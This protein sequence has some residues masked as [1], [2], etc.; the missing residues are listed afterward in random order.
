MEI[1]K[2]FAGLLQLVWS[3]AGV[4]QDFAGFCREFCRTLRL[5][6]SLAGTLVTC[7][8]FGGSFAGLYDLSEYCRGFAGVLQGV[9][10]DFYDV[11]EFCGGVLRDLLCRSFFPSPQDSV[12]GTFHR[13]LAD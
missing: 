3:L 7:N 1:G 9:L 6:W 12:A 11:R 10:Q 5:V 8:K 13:T 2:S 4:W